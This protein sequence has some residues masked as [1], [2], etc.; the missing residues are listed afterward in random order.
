MRQA[1]ALP[2]LPEIQKL[3]TESEQS[4]DSIH[5][6]MA[7]LGKDTSVAIETLD[8]LNHT[9]DGQMKQGQETSK[10]ME[11]LTGSIS[12]TRSMFSSVQADAK[13]VLDLCKSLDDSISN[14]SAISEENAASTQETSASME[15]INNEIEN[16]SKLSAELKEVSDALSAEL[17]FFKLD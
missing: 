15:D 7:T 1:E 6:I 17:D 5:E 13:T 16:I 9:V 10:S 4:A 8:R 3:S 12:E 2:L 14:L 11:S